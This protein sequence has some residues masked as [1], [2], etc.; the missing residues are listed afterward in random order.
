[1]PESIEI[2]HLGYEVLHAPEE[3]EMTLEALV[4]AD[5]WGLMLISPGVVSV[6]TWPGTIYYEVVGWNPST[7]CLVLR[8]QHRGG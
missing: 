6:G 2:Q 7:C 4:K 1:M 5:E 8:K 3:S